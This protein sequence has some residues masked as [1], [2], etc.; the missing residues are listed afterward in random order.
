LRKRAATEIE[1]TNEELEELKKCFKSA[2]AVLDTGTDNE[3]G[4]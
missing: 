2:A 4:Q 1:L 3:P